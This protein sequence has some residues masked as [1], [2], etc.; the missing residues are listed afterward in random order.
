MHWKLPV[1]ALLLIAL[2]GCSPS[3]ANIQLRKENEQL[4]AQV[5]KLENTRQADHAR[6]HTLEGPVTRPILP[7]T[8]LVRLYTAHGLSLGRL[9]GTY[10]DDDRQPLDSGIVVHVVP[11]DEDGQILK[12]AGRFDISAFDLADPQ[13]PLL[14]NHSFSLEEARQCWYGKAL[15]FNYV[16][17]VPFDLQPKHPDITIRIAY[18]DELTGRQFTTEKVVKAAT[19]K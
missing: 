19:P 13:H 12:A 8:E 4:R 17:K 1:I 6:I 11:V 16:L 15:L 3:K 10:K 14:G 2:V 18:T 9:T 5:A 7:E